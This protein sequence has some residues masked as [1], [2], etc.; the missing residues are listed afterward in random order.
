MQKVEVNYS[1]MDKVFS[2]GDDYYLINIF[3]IPTLSDEELIKILE[4]AC[5]FYATPYEKK[6]LNMAINE[7]KRRG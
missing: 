7:L 4:W 3:E 6:I 2:I 5:P 1:N